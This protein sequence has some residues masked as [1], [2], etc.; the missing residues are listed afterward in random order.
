MKFLLLE[1]EL[2]SN[3]SLRPVDKFIVQFLRN[4]CKSGKA[5]WGEPSYLAKEF[6]V[7]L[8]YIQQRFDFLERSKLIKKSDHGWILDCA[9]WEV[10]GFKS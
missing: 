5:Y 1:G 3:S 6:G 8:E 10:T 7:S 4:L 2:L 9:W